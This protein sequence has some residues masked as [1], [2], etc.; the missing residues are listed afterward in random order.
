[1]VYDLGRDRDVGALTGL[2]YVASSA[3]AITGPV[4]GGGLISLFG[5]NH[6]AI[7]PSSA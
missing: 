2:Y 4:L 6:S 1:M 5:E 7:W 3:A